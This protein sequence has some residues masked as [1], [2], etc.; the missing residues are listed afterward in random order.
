MVNGS[1]LLPRATLAM[2]RSALVPSFFTEESHKLGAHCAPEEAQRR[3]L[4]LELTSSVFWTCGTRMKSLR[5][6]NNIQAREKAAPLEES[7]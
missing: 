4:A 6:H 2:C 7:I 1:T 3:I 5:K